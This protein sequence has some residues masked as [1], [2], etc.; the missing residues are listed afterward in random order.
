MSQSVQD[1][2]QHVRAGAAPVSGTNAN[3][4]LGDLNAPVL[5]PAHTEIAVNSNS[6]PGL[7]AGEGTSS[8]AGAVSGTQPWQTQTHSQPLSGTSP[9]TPAP[10]SLGHVPPAGNTHGPADPINDNLLPPRPIVEELV[11]L[12]FEMVYPWAPMF[13]RPTFTAA[14]FYPERILLLHG[15]V[16]MA[17]RFWRK[18]EPALEVRDA[19]TRTSREQ[20]LLGTIDACTLTST[21]ALTLLAID[22]VGQGQ[23]PRTWNI[24]SM[25]VCAAKHLC[26]S[27]DSSSIAG[28][29]TSTPLV[30]NED[31]DDGL[32]PSSIEA[33]ERRRLF[34][35]IYSVDRLSSAAHGQLGGVDTKSIRLPYP[36]D[37]ED[38][39][40]P[41][42]PEW[43]RP[44]GGQSRPAVPL[45]Q[46]Q[47]QQDNN[48]RHHQPNFWR[49]TI[50]LLSMVDRSNQLL[51]Q[52]MN[53]SIPAHCRE[54]QSNFRRLDATLSTWFENLPREVRERPA[55]FDPTWVTMQATFH[56]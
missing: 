9:F 27:R 39:G 31:P 38:W 33:E 47:Q 13:F 25:L 51:V 32:D 50:D 28:A 5:S 30:R 48:P 55:N 11:N 14:M 35:V 7:P 19:Y 41:I 26:L 29:E 12:F 56:L 36:V 21:Q 53:Y 3:A 34:W 44:M 52:P 45:A 6:T 1:I 8:P 22:A 15:I 42:A 20:I 54:W 2:L 46:Q 49:Y 37:D 4:L 40:Q 23:G 24:M 10:M 43:F 18:P 16:V 17:F